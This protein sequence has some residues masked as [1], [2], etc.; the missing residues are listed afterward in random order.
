MCVEGIPKHK[1]DS[2]SW[3]DIKKLL[4]L[5]QSKKWGGV[6]IFFWIVGDPVM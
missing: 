6:G 3:M 2:F 4:G 1:S 5:Q